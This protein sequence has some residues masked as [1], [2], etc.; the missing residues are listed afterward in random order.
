MPTRSAHGPKW[1]SFIAQLL[2]SDLEGAAFAVDGQPNGVAPTVR[3]IGN[4]SLDREIV[5]CQQLLVL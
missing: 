1:W 5:S 4:I 3:I 2:L